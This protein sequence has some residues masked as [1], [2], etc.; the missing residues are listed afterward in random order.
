MGRHPFATVVSLLMA[1]AWVCVPWAAG[2][3]RLY[4]A[5]PE[6]SQSLY[7]PFEVEVRLDSP[8]EAVN[9]VDGW[10]ELGSAVA[11]AV[12]VSDGSSI[13]SLWVERPAP[14]PEGTGGGIRNAGSAVRFSGIVPGGFQGVG[15]KLFSVTLSPRASGE[16]PLSFASTTKVLL[17]GPDGALAQLELD[18]TSVVVRSEKQPV[19][20][21]GRPDRDAPEPFG[22]ELVQNPQMFDGRWTLVFSTTDKRSGVD[23]YEV[24]EQPVSW[25]SQLFGRPNWATATSPYLVRDQSLHR[26]LHVRALD[27]AG[28]VRTA[29][30]RPTAAHGWLGYGVGAAVLLLLLGSYAVRRWISRRR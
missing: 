18:E 4:F 20:G 26:V 27:R 24:W 16:L 6:L 12:D 29:T 11:A 28:N 2:A 15:G 10:L 7:A 8:D 25:W 30:L 23:R 5:A 1:A 19:F 22:L 9:A 3:A 14:P 21:V 17:H 13:V